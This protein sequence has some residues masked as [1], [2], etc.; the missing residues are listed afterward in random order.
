MALV[1]VSVV[2]EATPDA[3]WRDVA[4]IASHVEWM[5]DAESITFTSPHRQ[6]LGTTFDCATKIGP[7]RLLDRME[8]AEWQ[9]EA[10][11]GV[12]H[13]GIVT[14]QGR[15]TLEPVGMAHTRFAWREELDFPLRLG[16]A[17]GATVAAPV[18]RAVWKRNLRALKRRIEQQQV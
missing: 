9:P 6:G 10:A 1:E 12:R 13:Q 16:G 17:L 15:F 11:M 7:I 14:G 5:A 4:D 3:V 8:I 18:L 2:I